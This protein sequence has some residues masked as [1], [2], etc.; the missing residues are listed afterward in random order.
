MRCIWP[1]LLFAAAGC[2]SSSSTSNDMQT[3]SG[4]D[5]A[6]SAC[7]QT[8]DAYC[9]AAGPCVRDTASAQQAA[10]WCPNSTASG[11]AVTLQDCAGGQ[12]VVI[13]NYADSA[14]HFVYAGGALVAIFTAPPHAADNLAC[15]AG[16]TMIA[17]PSG[18]GAPTTLCAGP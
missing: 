2:G 16:P 14:N 13:A 15:I 4:P 17:A 12:T 1:L 8:V 9:A 18:C 3:A 10:S 6:T 7:A 5:L 11:G